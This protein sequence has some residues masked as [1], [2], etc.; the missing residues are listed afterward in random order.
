ML[1]REGFKMSTFVLLIFFSILIIFDKQIL[2]RCE[3]IFE[4]NPASW[5]RF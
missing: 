4:K 1:E 2:L 5:G 3:T